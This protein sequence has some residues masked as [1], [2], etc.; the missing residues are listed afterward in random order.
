MNTATD[1]PSPTSTILEREHNL[2]TT[3]VMIS[4]EGEQALRRELAELLD[5]RDRQLPRRLQRARE[6]GEA[7]GN[8][9]YLQILEE[10]AVSSARIRKITAILASAQVVDAGAEQGI[11][12]IGSTITLKIS[13]KEVERRLL[14]AHEPIGD[15]GVSVASPIG[16]A[17]LGCRA[18]ETVSAEL[19]SGKTVELEVVAVHARGGRPALAVAA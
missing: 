4:R 3:P 8:D 1:T 2:T 5:E 13:G 12:G 19:P 11:A 17:V 15:D 6:F 18:G 9:D 16:S 14:G 7:T 10:E